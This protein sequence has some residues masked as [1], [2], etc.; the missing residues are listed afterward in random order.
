MPDRMRF[1]WRTTPTQAIAQPL[2]HRVRS[3]IAALRA[4]AQ[5]SA[6]RAESIMKAGAPWNDITA[7]ARGALFG[8]A[9]DTNIEIGTTNFEYGLF[10]ELGTVNM[11]PR[12]IIVPTLDRTADQYYR[13][14]FTLARGILI[15]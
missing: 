5:T 7:Y 12:P 14:A 3:Y 4:L 6:A 2:Q 9:V 8:R 13:D 10:L 11:A 15:G 1:E